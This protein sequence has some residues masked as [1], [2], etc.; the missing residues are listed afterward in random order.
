[1]LVEVDNVLRLEQEQED[2]LRLAVQDEVLFT[3]GKRS[4]S[5]PRRRRRGRRRRRC[6]LPVQ[7]IHH[8]CKYLQLII[9]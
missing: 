8:C 1:M 4:S 5:S 3:R 2:I 9:Y 7:E 6:V